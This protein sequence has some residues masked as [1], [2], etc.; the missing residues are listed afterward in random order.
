M[1]VGTERR[2]FRRA[3]L[4]VPVE[5]RKADQKGAEINTVRGTV[6]DVSLAGFYCFIENPSDLK[7]G[8]LVDCSVSVTEEQVRFPFSR[9]LGRGWVT[10]LEPN[11]P[12]EQ[13]D[14]Q[15]S[16]KKSVVGLA[17]AFAPDVTALGTMSY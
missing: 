1:A 7:L 15:S 5:I 14:E 16:S 8:D 9:V 6:R 3:D 17:V 2:R 11:L 12:G 13:A 10:R 4:E